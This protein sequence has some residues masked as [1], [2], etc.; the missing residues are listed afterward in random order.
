M[1]VRPPL[2]TIKVPPSTSFSCGPLRPLPSRRDI[3]ITGSLTLIPRTT[4]SR[5][6]T[7][8]SIIITNTRTHETSTIFPLSRISP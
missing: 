3:T 1:E 8:F 6:P 4:K 7:T 2:P 5:E